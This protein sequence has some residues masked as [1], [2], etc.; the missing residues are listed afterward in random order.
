MSRTVT[1]SD[2]QW[3]EIFF[4]LRQEA[5]AP[6]ALS[7]EKERA[8]GILAVLL[9]TPWV[10]ECPVEISLLPPDQFAALQAHL[11]GAD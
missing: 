9:D 2:E 4:L 1:L 7:K 10:P 3:G 11:V 8:N 5:S 6:H